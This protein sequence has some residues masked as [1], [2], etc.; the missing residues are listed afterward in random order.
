[1]RPENHIFPLFCNGYLSLIIPQL[2]VVSIKHFV[3][4]GQL[5][6]PLTGRLSKNNFI[7]E[8]T[9]AIQYTV[10]DERYLSK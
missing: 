10:Q 3:M 4:R 6:N 2:P 1:M 5:I 7:R 9:C 8:E